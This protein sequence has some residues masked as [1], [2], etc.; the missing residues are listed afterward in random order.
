[1]ADALAVVK[2]GNI[3][4]EF[5]K[6]TPRSRTATIAGALS[7]VTLNARRPS[8]TNRIM[9]SGRLVW[10]AA[11]LTV[12]AASMLAQIASVLTDDI[13]PSFL[14]LLPASTVQH[15][16]CIQDKVS[17]A[18]GRSRPARTF[19]LRAFLVRTFPARKFVPCP[20]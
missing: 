16:P 9:L 6:F 12:T 1:M 18:H 2:V 17:G 20:G 8:G 3:E 15:P 11:A 19:P 5:L 14:R 13:F 7:G 4:C 10:A